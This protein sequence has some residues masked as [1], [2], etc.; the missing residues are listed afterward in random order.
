MSPR[1][2]GRYSEGVWSAAR[3]G[4]GENMDTILSVVSSVCAGTADAVGGIAVYGPIFAALV[5]T[6]CFVLLSLLG[7]NAPV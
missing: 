2:K 7:G 1:H 6:W 4:I 3:E 5:Q